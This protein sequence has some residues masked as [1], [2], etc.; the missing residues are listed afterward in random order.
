MERKDEVYSWDKLPFRLDEDCWGKLESAVK[1][2]PGVYCVCTDG[3]NESLFRELYV[4]MKAATP[5][6]ISPEVIARGVR[7]GDVWVFEYEG[8]DSVFH[9]VGYEITRYRVKCGLPTRDSL[10]SLAVFDAE[11]FPWYFGGTIPPRNTPFGLTVRVK[12]ADEG[13]FFLETDQ[14]RRLLAV[15]YPIWNTELSEETVELGVFC[16]DDL[17]AQA[18]ESRY[19]FFPKERCEPAIYELSGNRDH[20]GLQQL[21]SSGQFIP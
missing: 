13:L 9:L 17:A 3:E 8:V 15:S 6:I 14:C 18:Q 21:I 1:E 12:K 20:L 11:F 16:D 2:C 5:M 10:Y 4:V 7:E 19:L